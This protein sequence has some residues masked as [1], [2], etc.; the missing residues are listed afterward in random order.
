MKTVGQILKES[1]EARFYTLD[2]VE[3]VTKIRKE[4][5]IALESDD[6]AKLPPST[7]VQGFIKNYA[8][9][10]NI[11]ENKLLAVFRRGFEDKKHKPYIMDAF[12]NPV[13]NKKLILTPGTL[14]GVAVGVIVLSFFIYLWLQYRQFVG[15]PNLMLTSPQDQ[16]TTDS[17]TVSVEGKTEPETKVLINNQEISVNGDGTFKESISLTSQTNQIDVVAKSKFGQ[18]TEIDRVVYLKK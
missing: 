7:F 15:A 1:R 6:Y 2:Q 18:K 4:L 10:L 17:S 14:L 16:M 3:K 13:E 11:D 8:K 5:L 12:S 9:F